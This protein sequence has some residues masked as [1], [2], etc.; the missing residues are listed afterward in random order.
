[1]LLPPLAAPL[2]Y[3]RLCHADML[4]TLPILCC[5]AC[6]HVTTPISPPP[7]LPYAATLDAIAAA[8]RQFLVF[9]DDYDFSSADYAPA[10]MLRRLHL[11]FAAM[12][13]LCYDYAIFFRQLALLLLP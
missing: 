6:R 9:A 12:P 10:A 13:P 2:R 1:M 11:I 5:R 3:F 4:F 8:V 7:L